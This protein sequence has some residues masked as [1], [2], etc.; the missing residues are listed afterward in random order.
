MSEPLNVKIA[1]VDKLI[2]DEHIRQVTSNFIKSSSSNEFHPEGLFSEEIFGEIAS[3]RRLVSFGYIK[4]NTKVFHPRVYKNL[5]QLKRFYG[6]VLSSRSYARFDEKIGDFVTA[7]EDEQ[8]AGTGFLFFMKYYN[9]IQFKESPSLDRNDKIEILKKYK[10]D[11]IVD[12]WL[13]IPAGIRDI[14]LEDDNQTQE[15]INKFY[16]SLINL[17]NAIPEQGKNNKLYDGV[18]YSIQRKLVEIVEYIENILSGKTGFLQKKY[19]ARNLALGTRNVATSASF[20][21]ESIQSDQFLSV[22]ESM[23]G[24]FQ[25]TKC[26]QPAVIYQL[27]TLFFDNVFDMSAS[28]IS[29][30]NTK[31]YT[32]GYIPITE[33]EKDKFLTS[34]GLDNIINLCK[35]PH[36]RKKPI[37][38]IGDDKKHYYLFMVYDLGDK[39]Y[40]FRSSSDFKAFYEELGGDKFDSK[41]VRPL[42]YLEML[43]VCAW[44]VALD[45]HV[46]VTRYPAL[47]T[48]SIYP[49][50][51]HVASTTPARSIELKIVFEDTPGVVLPE[52]PILSNRAMDSFVTHPTK[53]NGLGLDFDGDMINV[54]GVL[55]EEA[56]KEIDEHL[57]RLESIIRAD[58]SLAINGG[59]DLINLTFLNLSTMDNKS[60]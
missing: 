7:S 10:D 47:G 46:L 8:D 40:Y 5:L 15:D 22:D 17:S 45:K 25:T 41:Y 34:K 21:K 27:K 14:Q 31:D 57:N 37:E 58:G 43:Y 35:D 55:T 49:S 26:F 3:E 20:D 48:E 38:V 50:K 39:L 2:R 36:F 42:T 52:Y 54:C 44:M 30:I 19:G 12:K 1:Q 6:D 53:W 18:R 9:S 33:T 11:V 16:S 32:L 56:N 23:M 13:V 29:V 59:V 4:L 60:A 24:T 28:Q 51:V